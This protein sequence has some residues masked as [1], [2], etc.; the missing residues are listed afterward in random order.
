[1]MNQRIQVLAL[2]KTLI[3]KGRSLQLT[4]KDYYL[5]RIRKEFNK[6]RHIES[7]EDIQRQIEKGY[8]FLKRNALV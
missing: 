8:S 3:R 4:D 2:Y 7:N 5:R 1:M 6:N